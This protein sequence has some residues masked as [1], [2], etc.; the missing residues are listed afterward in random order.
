[1]HLTPA[2]PVTV[3]LLHTTL[4][5]MAS[6]GRDLPVLV[7]PVGTDAAYPVTQH[8]RVGYFQRVESTRHMGPVG[9]LSP[10]S[11]D[12]PAAVALIVKDPGPSHILQ[13]AVAISRVAGSL[14]LNQPDALV[15][16]PVEGARKDDLYA[17]LD[18]K[19]DIENYAPE[20]SGRMCGNLPGVP[21]A[22]VLRPARL[23]RTEVTMPADWYTYL[24]QGTVCIDHQ[25]RLR[26]LNSLSFSE[27][28]TALAWL[29]VNALPI[30]DRVMDDMIKNMLSQ[31][32]LATPRVQPGH[33]A[34]R[35]REAHAWVT[36]TPL[37]R[38][39]AK[40]LN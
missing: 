16:V 28:M 40:V 12:G 11:A 34:L 25:G 37:A 6:A 39:L 10:W 5:M 7:S 2:Q 17:P 36:A 31:H 20:N 30:A 33:P 29:R 26:Y 21:M 3:A 19:I 8:V 24:A 1:M 22:H 14:T 32:A 4:A 13:C 9:L 38:E 35:V 27:A 18:H 23:A 15:L